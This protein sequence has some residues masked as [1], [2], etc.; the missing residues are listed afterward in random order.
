MENIQRR[1]SLYPR[2]PQF[3]TTHPSP[4]AQR[5]SSEVHCQ[6]H[7]LALATE[8]LSMQGSRINSAL[9]TVYR[10]LSGLLSCHLPL[11]WLRWTLSL[12]SLILCNVGTL[13]ALALYMAQARECPEDKRRKNGNFTKRLFLLAQVCLLSPLLSSNCCLYVQLET[14]VNSS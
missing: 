13:W 12:A 9:V 3:Q 1:L 4:A 10:F 5:R 11:V 14:T 7:H 2:A 6:F 8:C